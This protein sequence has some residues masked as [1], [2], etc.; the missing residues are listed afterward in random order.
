MS[1]EI[2]GL[3][4]R[5]DDGMDDRAMPSIRW[6]AKDDTLL[7]EIVIDEEIQPLAARTIQ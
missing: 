3:C 1:G 2:V 4:K 5:I 6:L 7:S